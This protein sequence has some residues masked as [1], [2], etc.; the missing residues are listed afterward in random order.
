MK[1]VRYK[2]TPRKISENEIK[3]LVKD[4]LNIKGYFNFH[5]MSGIGAFLGAPDRIAVKN[6]VYFIEVKGPNGIQSYH[7]KVFQ[8]RIEKAGGIY[9]LVRKL[10]DLIKGLEGGEK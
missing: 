8:E 2:L 5:L 4:W 1:A 9:I 3:K 6:K 10:E 7:Q